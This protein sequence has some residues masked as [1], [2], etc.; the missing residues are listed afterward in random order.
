M[1]RRRVFVLRLTQRGRSVG[2]QIEK[3]QRGGARACDFCLYF[4]A[5][6]PNTRPNYYQ[7]GPAPTLWFGLVG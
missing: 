6:Y 3:T 1:R 5:L 4:R 2:G 7:A